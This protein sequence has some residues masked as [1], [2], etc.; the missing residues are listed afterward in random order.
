MTD[1]LVV[2]GGLIGLLSARALSQTGAQVTLIERGQLGKESSWAGGGILS[3]LY[4]WKYPSA[5]NELAGW[6]QARYQLLADELAQSTG[7]DSEWVQSGL[8]MLDADERQAGLDWAASHPLGVDVELQSVDAEKL[9]TL[10]PNLQ[11]GHDGGLLMSSVAQ[12]RNPSFAKALRLDLAQRGVRVAEDTEVTHL[13]TKKGRILGVRTD[14]NEVMADN[15]IIS[16]GAWSATLLKELGQSVPVMPVRGQM[17]LF[18]AE[19]GLLQRIIL[20]E[21][22]YVIPRKDGR[23]LIGS[24]MEE[25]GFDK[26][27]TDEARDDLAAVARSLVPA[28]A[29]VPMERHWA[30]LRPGSPTGVPFIGEH[31][32]VEGLFINAGHFRNGVVMAP[33]SA[34]LLADIILDRPP[35]VDPRPYALENR[36]NAA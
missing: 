25:V 9:Q 29:N 16:C 10:E 3:P 13:L 21:G 31:P 5:V 19:P 2:G 28:L 27:V 1:F 7:V 12:I 33:A 24:T 34:E 26:T 20:H 8:L 17:I 14:Y 15:V 35:S 11:R 32:V 30:G 22:H 36:S 4:P 6:S 23:I 18:R